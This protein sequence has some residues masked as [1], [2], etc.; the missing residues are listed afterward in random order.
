MRTAARE[1]APQVALRGC[2]KEVG[3]EKKVDVCMIW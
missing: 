1:T 3:G 2:S